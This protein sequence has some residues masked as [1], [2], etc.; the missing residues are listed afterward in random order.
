M[1][2]RFAEVMRRARETATKARSGEEARQGRLAALAEA[3]VAGADGRLREMRRSSRVVALVR[4][5]EARAK[6][7]GAVPPE[8]WTSED[9]AEIAALYAE[10]IRLEDLTGVAHDVDHVTPLSRGGLH[11]AANMRVTTAHANRSKGAK[12]ESP[13]P[14]RGDPE[15]ERQPR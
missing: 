14:D 12:A 9:R 3:A 5:G 1:N 6:K 13:E 10:A 15:S 8:G 7:M 2:A 11:L 4:G